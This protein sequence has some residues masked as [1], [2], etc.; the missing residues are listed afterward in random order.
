MEKAD[1]IRVQ[2]TTNNLTNFLAM[3]VLQDV[4]FSRRLIDETVQ[5]RTQLT[6]KLRLSTCFSLITIAN[7]SF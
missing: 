5:L 6:E 2:F 4:N 1:Q 7:F 3:K